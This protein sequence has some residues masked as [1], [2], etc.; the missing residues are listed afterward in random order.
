MQFTREFFW[1]IVYLVCLGL[2][3]AAFGLNYVDFKKNKNVNSKKYERQEMA[4]GFMGAVG[5]IFSIPL[6]SYITMVMLQ[7]RNRRGP[8]RM[9]SFSNN[10]VTFSN[11][12]RRR[13]K[14]KCRS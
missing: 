5:I 7:F 1:A 4:V 6:L 9:P 14:K 11:F 13:K 8:M 3:W 12:G 2:I 10:I